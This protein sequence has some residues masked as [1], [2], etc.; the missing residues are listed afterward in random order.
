[1][2]NRDEE[3][4]RSHGLPGGREALGYSQEASLSPPR[5][6]PRVACRSAG[7]PITRARALR[8]PSAGQ[9]GDAPSA[10]LSQPADAR[11]QA[12]GGRHRRR[13]RDRRLGDAVGSDLPAP[14][15]DGSERL[16]YEAEE[17]A[18]MA[19]R[20]N[21][22]KGGGSGGRALRLD[23]GGD[24]ESSSRPPSSRCQAGPPAVSCPGM[25]RRGA[26]GAPGSAP[27]SPAARPKFRG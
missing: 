8:G 27:R 11:S 15:P 26:S 24:G 6:A 25:R 22:E 5:S 9:D 18:Q 3:R 14:V 10:R 20:R 17:L 12:V 13:V 23:Q 2:R 1:M 7:A 16:R 21:P 19:V 4:R